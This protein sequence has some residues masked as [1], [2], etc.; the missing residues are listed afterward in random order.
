MEC[1]LDRDRRQDRQNANHPKVDPIDRS[2]DPQGFESISLRIRGRLPAVAVVEMNG[3]FGVA[4]AVMLRIHPFLVNLLLLH[5]RSNLSRAHAIPNGTH[6]HAGFNVP[7]PR[8]G[9]WIARWILR[10]KDAEKSERFDDEIEQ[11]FGTQSYLNASSIMSSTTFP[12]TRS[13]ED[14]TLLGRPT[15]TP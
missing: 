12:T 1:P 7:R 6:A 4:Q 9:Q 10:F 2:V 15:P 14:T 8:L 11:R 5:C 13:G 3:N